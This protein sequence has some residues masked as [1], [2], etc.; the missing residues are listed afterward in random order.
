M[1]GRLKSHFFCF[2]LLISVFSPLIRDSNGLDPRSD[3]GQ[4]RELARLPSEPVGR[5]SIVYKKYGISGGAKAREP[6]I[7]RKLLAL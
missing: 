6:V 7:E 5:P 3:N 1:F 4:E 2:L